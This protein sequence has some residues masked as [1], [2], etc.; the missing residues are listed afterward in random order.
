MKLGMGLGLRL[1]GSGPSGRA[2]GLAGAL[3]LAP[4]A[5]VM[6]QPAPATVHGGV[7]DPTGAPLS[8]GPAEVRFSTDKSSPAKERKYQYTF[9]VS[10]DATYKATG[11]AP[12]DYEV[13]IFQGDKS[14][15]FQPLTVKAGADDTLDFDMSRPE[16]LKA[17]TPE[18]RAKIEEVK[19]KNAAALAENSQIKN[20]NGL[21]L[22]TRQLEKTDPDK[23]VATIQPATTL[24]PNEPIIWAS[25]GEAQLSAADAAAKAAGKTATPDP[26]VVQKYADTVVSYQKAVD[27]IKAQPK[28]NNDLLY[29]CELNMGQAY[30]KS[31][32]TDEA[33]KAYDAAA[34]ANPPGAAKAY[35]NESAT[36]YN[37]GKMDEA[38]VAADK[39][40]QADP[41]NAEAYYIKGQALIPKATMDAKTNKIVLP[42]GCFEAYQ[43]YLE[44]APTG[45]HVTDVR[46][47][48]D[49]ADQTQH[50]SYKA[51]RKS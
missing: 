46:G 12:G 34:A 22:E 7:K 11:V 36:L 2:I 21:L 37:A 14:I 20:L 30:G 4:P 45:A 42:P 27:L 38:A 51:G 43:K 28:P 50:S 5:I 47:I 18:E 48:L 9:P 25:L 39:T 24:R 44:L 41:K 23:A 1:L 33:A 8:G 29:S 3:L 31:G 10:P 6:A 13:F 32:K 40:I 19:K 15:D 49:N 26:A 35:F 17:L 16:Y